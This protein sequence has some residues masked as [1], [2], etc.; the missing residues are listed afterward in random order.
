ME[1]NYNSKGHGSGFEKVTPLVVTI[2]I[3]NI[4]D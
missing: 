3:G 2:G 1:M 4:M